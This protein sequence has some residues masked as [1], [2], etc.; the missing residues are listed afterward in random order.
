MLEDGELLDVHL[1]L[2]RVLDEC[3]VFLEDGRDICTVQ[4]LLGHREVSAPM[5]YTQTLNCAP[6][7]VR[8]STDH[9]GSP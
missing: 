6:V 7:G 8:S 3:H 9:L 4:E 5:I 2:Q 1:R